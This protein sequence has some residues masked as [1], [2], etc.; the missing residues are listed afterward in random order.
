MPYPAP[1]PDDLTA[2]RRRTR[3]GMLAAASLIAAT[4]GS[5]LT[6]GA[7]SAA[8]SA[9]GV[10]HRHTRLCANAKPGNAACMA[11]RVDVVTPTGV[12]PAVTPNAIPSG[13]GPSSLQSAYALPSASA[14]SG[15]T[16][17]IVD[18]Y[19]DP[20]AESDLAAY[21]TQFGLP[22]CTTANGCFRK[23][24]QN[25]STTPLPAANSGW[26]GEIALDIDMVSAVCPNCRILLVEASSSSLADLG[27]AVNR[28]VAMGAKFVSN[29][30][31]GPESGSENTYDTS[32]YRH[33]GVAITASSGDSD[34][35]GG[36]YPATSKYVTAV[37]GTSL[38]TA[39]TPRGW[40]ESVW[41]T[42]SYTEGAGSGCSKSVTKPAFQ[43]G[44]ATGCANRAES[45]VS[46]VA[47][48]ATGVAVYSTYGGSGWAV[49]GGTSAAAPIVASTYALAGAPG[50]SD[51]PNAYPYAHAASLNDVTSGSNGTCGAPLCTA[52]AGWDGPTGLGTPNGLAAFTAGTS[53]APAPVAVANPGSKTG[54]VGTAT[55]LQLSASGGT[56]PYT[57]AASGLPT[58]LAISGSGLISGTP[59]AAGTF[60]VTATARDSAGATGS[61]TFTWTISPA[62]S[63]SCTGQKILNPGFE[64]GAASWTATSGV[65]NTDGGHSRT[66]TGYAWLDGYGSTHTDS[67]AQS[68]SIPAGCR[69]TLSY[70]LFISSSEGTTTAYD[71]LAVTVNGATVQSFSNV[72]KGSGYV[73]RSVDVSA[74]AGQTVT[75]KWTGTEDSS[76]A[77]SFFVDDTALTLG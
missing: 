41:N 74:Y 2:H 37:G 65:I 56:A 12:T 68:V 9:T 30:Y 16:V 15:Q 27:T 38:R 58:G 43:N 7:A 71:K 34:Y 53:T 52:G 76:L 33:A 36:S 69:A 25:G 3:R 40:S 46:A 62:G 47:D 18:A 35:D 20:N 13:Y 73:L 4:V 64:S 50:A 54:T 26:A 23:V 60:S 51:Y 21:R 39:S 28:A 57:W 45:D 14:G 22:A 42:T 67:I 32:Y 55:S 48:P 77:T 11:I 8:P 75:L 5:V 1:R 29:S 66:G 6:A 24:N 70:Y 72:N 19:D 63:S 49:Y 61:A 31:G 10:E 59:S 17:A 44:I